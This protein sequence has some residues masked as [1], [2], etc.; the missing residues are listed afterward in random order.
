MKTII[1]IFGNAIISIDGETLTGVSF[2]GMELKNADFRG[3]D[4]SY[5]DFFR[6]DI[7][8]A[9]F[10]GA[11]LNNTGIDESYLVHFGAKYDSFTI[12]DEETHH[13]GFM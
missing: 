5:S 8:G 6:A 7:S 11:N 3:Q 10:S 9:D 2:V 4:L 13:F 12:F 1:D